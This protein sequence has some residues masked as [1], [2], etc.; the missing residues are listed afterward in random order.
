[1]ESRDVSADKTIDAF[2]KFEVKLVSHIHELESA[3]KQIEQ[4]T[5][6]KMK[7]SDLTWGVINEIATKALWPV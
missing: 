7:G 2:L 5:R 1:M 3:L 4:I 6:E